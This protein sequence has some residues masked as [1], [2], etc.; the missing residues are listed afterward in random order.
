MPAESTVARGVGGIVLAQGVV[1]LQVQHT[2]ILVEV[3]HGRLL[4]Q[5]IG[6]LA[7][8]SLPIV[9]SKCQVF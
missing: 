4:L 9:R 8:R 1:R 6:W 7:E 3:I 2:L 5:D